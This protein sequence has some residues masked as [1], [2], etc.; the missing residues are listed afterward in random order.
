MRFCRFVQLGFFVYVLLEFAARAQT[1]VAGTTPGQFSVSE[2]GAA[3]YGIP[4]QIPP[5]LAGM[6]PKLALV[7]NSQGGNGLLGVGWN[8]SGLSAISRCPRTMAQDGVRGGV[9]FDI[10]DRYCMDGQ[11]LILVAGSYGVASSEYRTEIENFSK[12]TAYGTAGSASAGDGPAYFIVKTKA[13]ITM[14]YGNSAQSRIEAQGRTTV[15]SWAL[16]KVSDTKGNYLTVSYAENNAIG[17]AYVTQIDY[18]GNATATPTVAPFASVRFIYSTVARVDLVTGYVAGS[19]QTNRKLM[20][21]VQTYLS[22]NQVL[23]YRLTYEQGTPTYQSRLKTVTVCEQGGTCMS[24]TTFGWGSEVNSF[25]NVIQPAA[26]STFN[27][28]A[29]WFTNSYLS[30]VFLTDVNGDGRPDIMGIADNYIGVQLNTGSGFGSIQ[31]WAPTSSPST[32]SPSAGW[33]S[34]SYRNRVYVVDVNGDGLPD[35]MAIDNNYVGVQ[36]NT[37]SGFGPIQTWATSS[38]SPNI[39]WFSTAYQSRVYVADVNGDGLPDIMAIDNN[40]IGVQLNTGSS[41]GPIQTWATSSFNPSA[42][43]FSTAYQSRVYLADVNGDGLPDIMAIDNNYIG[44]Q[45]NTGSGFGPIQTWA[46]SSFSP[47]AGW[48]STAYQSRVYVVD[49]NGDG[50][51]DIMAIDNNYVGVQLNTGT[52]FGPIQPWAPASSPSSFSPSAGWFSTSY[53]PRVYVVDVNGDGLPDIMGIDNNYVG[54]YLNTG[55]GFQP[56]QNWATT[57]FS[58]SGGWF[59]TTQQSRVY[60]ADVNG[61]GLLDIMGIADNYV[62]VQST[63]GPAGVPGQFFV[64]SI[65]SGG[66]ATTSVAY[67]PIASSSVY[68]K[69]FGVNASVFPVRDLQVPIFVVSSVG[70]SDGVGGTSFTDHTY[71]GLKASVADGRGLLGYRW[72]K[73]KE[74]L[75]NIE[76]YSEYRQDFPYTGSPIKSET[77][78]AGS[79]NAG[80]LKRTT[81]TPGCKIPQTAAACA[82]AAGNRYFPYVTSTVEESWEL[83]GTAYPS[84]TTSYLYAQSPVYGDP[85]QITVTNNSDASNKTTVNEYLPADTTNWILGRLT[86]ATVTSVGATGGSGA[87]AAGAQALGMTVNPSSISVERSNSGTGV[88]SSTATASGGYSPYSFSWARVGGTKT[89]IT[90]GATATPTFTATVGWGENFTDTLRATLTDGIGG[91]IT[92]D[93]SVNYWAPAALTGTVS[94]TASSFA[95]GCTDGPLATTSVV[96]ASGAYPPYQYLWL[97]TYSAPGISSVTPAG[98]SATI[99]FS[100]NAG[101]N[102]EPFWSGPISYSYQVRVTDSRGNITTPS[103]SFVVNRTCVFEGGGG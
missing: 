24:P 103:G 15:K 49:I 19:L 91:T 25:S 84:I 67:K 90:N 48:F 26:S 43:W 6:E 64:T 98:S 8:L 9:N 16:N 32:F 31:S 54:V 1:T 42:G 35:I 102:G 80:V 12:I 13:G 89:V 61:D 65:N 60:V 77:R 41:F 37:G 81:A 94:T 53:Q 95:V 87:N 10:N 17:E 44:V 68:T 3:A 52:G 30:R 62:G 99:N 88:T 46:T 27:P 101:P 7:Y 57:S 83:N 96:T 4:I 45:L 11:R 40:Y 55:S 71:G 28:N 85:T 66:G 86:K 58:P 23:D 82:V 92:R 75:T 79:G 74:L 56:L 34:T 69:D 22:T 20:T 100:Q 97:V 59:T 18:T 29:G 50:L 70:A 51:P 78:L 63:A 93:V 5:G 47:S 2:S 73:R 39:G 21:N 38:F 76:S 36:L 14:E 72:T 33:F